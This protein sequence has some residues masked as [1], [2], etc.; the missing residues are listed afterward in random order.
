MIRAPALPRVIGHRGAAGLAPENT[1]AAVRAAKAVGCT[2][3]EVDVTLS[4]DAVPLL[5]HDDSLERTTDGRGRVGDH[6][7][8]D[9]RRLDAGSRFGPA[10]AGERV[11]L[12]SEL[13]E[14]AAEL[15]LAVDLEIKPA[16]GRE[17]ETAERAIAVARAVWPA[18]RPA[19]LLTSFSETALDAA[20]RLAG[21]WPRGWLVRRIPAD[22]GGGLARFEPAMVGVDRRHATARAVAAVRRAGPA[23]GAYTVDDPAEAR[24]LAGI[25][26]DAVFSDRPDAVAPALGP[27]AFAP[28][29]T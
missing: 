14:T 1:L 19:P 4:R 13:L 21:D 11:P 16:R 18:D 28:R 10:F 7:V 17:A 6:D 15:D 26:I 2:W 29:D 12:L 24:R 8:A 3:I 25:G 22:P 5:M 20:R 9:L 27:D 23:V